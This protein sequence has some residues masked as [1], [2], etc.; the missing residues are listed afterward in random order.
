MDTS[1]INLL[2]DAVLDRLITR[3]QATITDATKVQVIHAGLYRE[4]HTETEINLFVHPA[5]K[6]WRD[7]LNIT[8]D[9]YMADEYLEMGS[10]TGSPLWRRR[11]ECEIKIQF[12]G[13]LSQQQARE[14][15]MVVKSRAEKELMTMTLGGLTDS[16]GESALNMA[17][18][19]VD[20]YIEEAAEWGWFGCIRF[21]VITQKNA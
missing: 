21:E 5:K 9:G 6:D 16:F 13:T 4:D 18:Q 8:G 19:V 1:I 17:P 2:C 12:D 14:V 7:T 15:S 11:F 10:Y 3:L 20:S